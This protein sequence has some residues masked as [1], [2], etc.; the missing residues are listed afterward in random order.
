M[1]PGQG[2]QGR[3]RQHL[4]RAIILGRLQHHVEQEVLREELA[5]QRLAIANHRSR[6]KGGTVR[7]HTQQPA[8]V[9]PP[10][11][12]AA[13]GA[14]VQGVE[15]HAEVLEQ[16]ALHLGHLDLEHH[17]LAAA[18]GEQV[19]HLQR[20][21]RCGLGRLSLAL[22]NALALCRVGLGHLDRGVHRRRAGYLA[23]QDQRALGTEHRDPL[24]GHQF[25][26]L[27]LQRTEVV[28]HLQI[29]AVDQP[30]LAIPQQHVGAA[31]RA[32]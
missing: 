28:H 3:L 21:G 19:D 32:A 27:A 6:V 18:D 12:P 8:I 13:G 10:P 14:E 5:E 15:A 31:Q 16:A 7:R 11:T 23:T 1:L 26:E 20:L 30:A 4:G 29:E 22:G 24:V 25:V 2:G 9:E 17:L